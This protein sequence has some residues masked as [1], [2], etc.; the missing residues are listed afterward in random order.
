MLLF[1][2]GGAGQA[3]H[4]CV[5][6]YAQ[7][8]AR[9]RTSIWSLQVDTGRGPHRALTVEVDVG[10]R[11]IRQARGKANRLPRQV[12]REVLERWAGQEGLRFADHL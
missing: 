4:H 9:G 12:E 11:T 7:D 5:A 8:C 3:L 2:A 6:S 1:F 10:K